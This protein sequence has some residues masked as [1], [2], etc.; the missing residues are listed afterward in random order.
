MIVQSVEKCGVDESCR[1]DHGCRPDQKF[2]EHTS[3]AIS[4]HLR[5]KGEEELEA[6]AKVVA[7][8]TLHGD[9]GVGRVRRARSTRVGDIGHDGDKTVLFHVEFTWAQKLGHH[10][11]PEVTEGISDQLR[12][13]SRNDDRRRTQREEQ[14][15]CRTERNHEH[16]DYPC[17]NSICGHVL[18]VVADSSSD[19]GIWRVV[20]DEVDQFEL[21]SGIVLVHGS[22]H[23]IGDIVGHVRIP[24]V[25]LLEE[26]ELLVGLGF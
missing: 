22:V 26:F 17:A 18:V 11:V 3:E 4:K 23:A 20:F 2:T 7:V 10:Q 13:E 21:S 8:K 1:P 24:S 12:N 9:N 5:G 16:T 15:H 14:I 25:E 6:P 19:F